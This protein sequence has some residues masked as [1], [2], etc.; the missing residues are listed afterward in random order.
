MP[1][2][3]QDLKKPPAQAFDALEY[4]LYLR[5]RWRF[6]AIAVAV[7]GLLALGISLLLPKQYTSTSSILIEP[8]SGSDPRTFTAISPI[9]LE[10][11]KTYELLAMSDSLFQRAVEKFQ[12]RQ[13]GASESVE[14]LKSRVIKVS[15]LRDT[16]VLQIGITLPDPAEA[17][18]MAQFIAEETEKLSSSVGRDSGR[19]LI[20]DAQRQSDTARARLDEAQAAWS[21][22]S[23]EQPMD[24][25][26]GE[27]SSMT[28]LLYRLQRNLAENE[29]SAAEYEL[30]GNAPSTTNPKD[31][32]AER[33]DDARTG[34]AMRARAEVFRKQARELEKSLQAK[35]ALLAER[36]ARREQFDLQRKSAQIV[37][38]TASRRSQDLRTALGSSGERLRI[39]D[40]GIVPERPSEPKTILHVIIAIAVALLGSIVYLSLAFGLRS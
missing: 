17:Q 40:P 30:R 26:I 5:K 33:D 14:S 34:A 32:S 1:Y 39:I 18:A 21:K 13:K 28:E 38:D 7:A 35:S 25:L 3:F 2:S 20:A 12:L 11:L 6:S 24:L 23:S 15:K 9:Y 27:L 29:A 10:S 4:V 19:D 16:K 37:Y 22:I 8:P 31:E 36:G